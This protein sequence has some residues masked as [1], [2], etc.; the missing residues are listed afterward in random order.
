MNN[1]RH[2]KKALLKSISILSEQKENF[3]FN[4]YLDF[5]RKRKLPFNELIKFIIC[6]ESGAIKDELYKYFGLSNNVITAS[7]FIQQRKKIKH[8]AFKYIFETFHKKLLILNRIKD[9]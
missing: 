2:L 8:E 5:T 9:I 4:P 3:L 1:A 6:M 7:A